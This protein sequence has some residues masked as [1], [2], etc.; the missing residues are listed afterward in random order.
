MIGHKVNRVKSLSIKKLTFLGFMLVALPLVLALLYS[1]NQVNQLSKQGANAIFVVAEL[2]NTNQKVSNTLKKMERYASQ[3]L[4]LQDKELLDKYAIEQQVLLAANE[5]LNQ[6]DD[7]EIKRLSEQ[8]S[9]AIRHVD[10]SITTPAQDLLNPNGQVASISLEALQ[11]QFKRLISINDQ[12]NKRSN[13]LINQQAQE[14]K[15]ATA[16]VS[17]TLLKSL[18]IIPVSLLIAGLFI[19]LITKPLKQLII[20][21]QHLQQGNFQHEADAQEKPVAGFVEIKEIND[22]LNTM[23][24]RLHALELQK[25]SFIRHISHELKTPLAAIR[26]GTELLYDNSVGELNNSQLEVTKIIRESTTR[27]QRLI[28]ELLDFNIVLDSTSLQDKETINLSALIEQVL[29]DRTLD[30]KRKH[31]S[32]E[33]DYASITIESNAKQLNVIID[34]LLSNAIK[35]SPEYGVIKISA[36]LNEQQLAFSVVDQGEGIKTEQQPKVFDAFYQGTPPK[37][38]TIKSSGLG[39][40]IVKELLMRLNGTISLHSQTHSPSGTE[41]KVIINGVVSG[42]NS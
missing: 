4:V 15:D 24:S 13:K 1:S 12:I 5:Q 10:E 2:I 16:Q 35:Y 27:L 29:S 7:S 21:I 38:S 17:H 22:A 6:H 30:I 31:L 19:M 32:I 20:K 26:E 23:R 8:F 42:E 25:S 39:L 36:V 9:E 28:E 40:T 34:N 14:I 3:Y 11:K 33:K 41:M 18:L 37:D